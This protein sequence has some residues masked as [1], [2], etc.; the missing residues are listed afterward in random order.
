MQKRNKPQLNPNVQPLYDELSVKFI[1]STCKFES[2]NGQTIK[3]NNPK[4]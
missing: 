4:P 3:N 1:A 2:E